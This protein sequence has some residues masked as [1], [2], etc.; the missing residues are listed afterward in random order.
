MRL[1]SLPIYQV[2]A[3][4]TKLFQGNPAAVCPLEAWLPDALMQSIAQENN[5][6]ETAFFV[7]QGEGFEIR[8][9]TPND[10]VALCGHATLASAHVL[11]EELGYNKPTIAL[12]SPHS[13]PL[14]VFKK[15]GLLFLDFPT[16]TITPHPMAPAFE[17][18]LGVRP[19]ALFKGK[20]DYIALL[21]NEAAVRGCTPNMAKVDAI[22][23]RGI[24]ITAGGDTV[25]IVSRFFAPQCA[26]PEDPV[27][28]S[29]HTSL[30]PLW[31]P[32]LGKTKLV[33]RQLSQRGGQLHCELKEDRCWIGGTAV[34]YLKGTLQLH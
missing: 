23:G 19:T 6:S 7:P 18:A 24:I 25:D 11:F 9:F 3:F 1:K 31:A 4:A 29:A 33:A 26:V 22:G 2:D 10:E 21:E 13:G 17:A 15:D 28:G 20:T 16:D 8:W 32:R 34:T 30:L 5:L 14:K 12:H 27:T